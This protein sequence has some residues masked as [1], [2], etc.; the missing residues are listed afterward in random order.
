MS[1]YLKSLLTVSLLSF[2]AN[3]LT[4]QHTS[5]AFGNM[6]NCV[7]VLLLSS[8]MEEIRQLDIGITVQDAA[9]KKLGTHSIQVEE[10]GASN[11]TDSRDEFLG[12]YHICKYNFSLVVTRAVGI[13]D[14]KKVDLLRDKLVEVVDF[15]PAPIRLK[16]KSDAKR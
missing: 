2:Q 14:D 4:I 12:G 13:M 16:A 7:A 8:P 1:F 15:K 9:G 11:A 6:E 3:A 5:T 10:I